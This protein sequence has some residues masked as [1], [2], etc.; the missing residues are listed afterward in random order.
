MDRIQNTGLLAGVRE[1]L[2]QPLRGDGH[3]FLRA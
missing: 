2:Q 1:R 3:T